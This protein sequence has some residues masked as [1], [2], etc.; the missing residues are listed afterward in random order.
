MTLRGCMRSNAPLI[1]I[2]VVAGCSDNG[3]PA[4]SYKNWKDRVVVAAGL[5]SVFMPCMIK[6]GETENVAAY[7]VMPVDQCYKM[8]PPQRWKGLWSNKFGSS[9]FCPAPAV[10]CGPETA[11]DRIWL[12]AKTEPLH[13]LYSVDFIGRQTTVKGRYERMCEHEVI[14]DRMVAIKRIDL[15]GTSVEDETLK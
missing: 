4:S 1:A 15:A 13:G 12:D 14:V 6:T 3:Q 5:S 8:D 2:A 7:E 9:R 10:Q 11:G